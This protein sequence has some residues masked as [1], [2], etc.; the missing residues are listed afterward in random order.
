MRFTILVDNNLANHRCRCEHGLSVFVEVADECYLLD[1]GQSSKCIANADVL[2]IDLCRLNGAV[3]SHGHYDHTGGLKKL[4]ELLPGLKLY[5]SPNARIPKYSVSTVMTKYNGM[6]NPELLDV[7]NY[8][9]VHSMLEV[10]EYVTL[11]TLPGVAPTNNHLM[12]DG[13]EGLEPDGFPDEV[14]TLVKEGEKSVLFG[15]CT[16]HGLEQLLTYVFGTLGVKHVDAFVGG[17]H[18]KGRSEEEIRKSV[19]VARRFDVRRWVVNH[20]TGNEAIAI[21]SEEFEC[22]AIDGYTGSSFEI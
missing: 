7:M 8:V 1:M 21:W 4:H 15:G 22:K 9:A 11:F 13:V 3:V 6:P 19:D 20:C 14:F 10:S 16:H 18:L 17:L 5:A 12:V 2:G